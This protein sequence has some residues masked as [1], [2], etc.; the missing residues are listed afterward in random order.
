MAMSLSL[1]LM[2]QCQLE[3][4]I[5]GRGFQVTFFLGNILLQFEKKWNEKSDWEPYPFTLHNIMSVN[6][7]VADLKPRI[8][9]NIDKL[10]YPAAYTFCQK[11]LELEPHNAEILEIT[12]QVELELEQFE[13][14]R[15]VGLCSNQ[16]AGRKY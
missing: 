13:L 2:V 10:E 1:F 9:E 7:T 8:L 15:K 4:L 16:H 3:F 14:A 12:G 6:Y 5:C 11:A